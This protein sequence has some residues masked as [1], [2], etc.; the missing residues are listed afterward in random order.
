[1]SRDFDERP[2]TML[3][4]AEL[5]RLSFMSDVDAL[6]SAM[7]TDDKYAVAKT[8]AALHRAGGGYLPSDTY[9]PVYMDISH[10]DPRA[11]MNGERNTE[12]RLPT[13][14]DEM[15]E[16]YDFM[17]H[18]AD[19]LLENTPGFV[20]EM[21][22]IEEDLDFIISEVSTTP[23]PFV[24]QHEDEVKEFRDRIVNLVKDEPFLPRSLMV[25]MND[26]DRMVPG[27]HLRNAPELEHSFK[28][29]DQFEPSQQY[30]FESTPE[31]DDTDIRRHLDGIAS[32]KMEALQTSMTDMNPDNLHYLQLDAELDKHVDAIVDDFL[33]QADVLGAKIPEDLIVDMGAQ[34]ELRNHEHLGEYFSAYE[35]SKLARRAPD[36]DIHRTLPESMNVEQLRMSLDNVYE[37]L[38]QVGE[39]GDLRSIQTDIEIEGLRDDAVRLA[40]DG[41]TKIPLSTMRMM[42]LVDHH[43]MSK[44]VF[45]EALPEKFE[46]F[47]KHEA[48]LAYEEL[49]SKLAFELPYRTAGV[50]IASAAN[51]NLDLSYDRADRIINDVVDLLDKNDNRLMTDQLLNVIDVSEL[52]ESDVVF[53]HFRRANAAREFAPDMATLSV[54]VEDTLV[55]SQKGE[56]DLRSV[57]PL[58]VV[59]RLDQLTREGEQ[60]P[61]STMRALREIDQATASSTFTDAFPEKFQALAAYE[62]AQAKQASQ[63]APKL[64]KATEKAVDVERER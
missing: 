42:D 46:A 55:R 49:C 56:I 30:R 60:V 17:M 43:D 34:K 40:S 29:F 13:A 45:R 5:G 53:D 22:E 9:T 3:E 31:F 35:E 27:N 6:R 63:D 23:L 54:R 62:D 58:R 24:D 19:A 57:N 59:D 36:A 7:K 48:N 28:V 2:Q 37:R 8:R 10:L 1:M 61:L 33:T 39:R 18:E 64:F 52:R 4:Y 21:A 26:L 20:I 38:N 47:D 44:T 16:A 41:E 14:T 11:D 15:T 50:N 51:N 32:V 25:R 12:A